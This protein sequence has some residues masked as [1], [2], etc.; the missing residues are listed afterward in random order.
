[1]VIDT[2]QRLMTLDDLLA[3]GEDATFEII[4]GKVI[5]MP[6]AGGLHQ[7]VAYNLIFI[8]SQ[9]TKSMKKLATSFQTR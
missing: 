6:P 7:I 4:N 2:Q 5:E 8:L 9:Y 3:Q 1:M